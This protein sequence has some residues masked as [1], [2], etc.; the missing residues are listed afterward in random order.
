MGLTRIREL[1]WAVAAAAVAAAAVDRARRQ[2]RSYRSRFQC[3]LKVTCMQC[4]IRRGVR[5]QEKLQVAQ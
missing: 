3:A 1:S 2:T 4:A 5:F